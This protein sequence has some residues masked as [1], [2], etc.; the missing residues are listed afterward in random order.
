MVHVMPAEFISA[1]ET[2]HEGGV[3]S[4]GVVA[5]VYPLSDSPPVDVG[6]FQ[7]RST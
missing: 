4:A 1:S 5:T 7:I 6:A 2:G 3:A